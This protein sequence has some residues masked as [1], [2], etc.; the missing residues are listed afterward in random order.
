MIK[1]RQMVK[2]VW[3]SYLDDLQVKIGDTLNDYHDVWFCKKIDYFNMGDE[4]ADPTACLFFETLD[5]VT[6]T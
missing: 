4:E 1:K 3:A 2:I 5:E 6:K